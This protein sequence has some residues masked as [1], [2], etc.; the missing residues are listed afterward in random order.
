MV[1]AIHQYECRPQ[2]YMCSPHPEPLSLLTPH[3]V[4]LGCPRALASNWPSIL[5]IVMYLFQCYSLK[6]S[7]PCLL[8]LSP[9]VWGNRQLS[10]ESEA[11]LVVCEAAGHGRC[12]RKGLLTPAAQALGKNSKHF[13]DIQHLFLASQMRG[14]MTLNG[15]GNWIWR[16]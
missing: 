15:G 11:N 13:W 5:H 8:P 2:V 12:H 14:F 6:S 9:K 3:P 7:H 10:W 16:F 1:F 4:P